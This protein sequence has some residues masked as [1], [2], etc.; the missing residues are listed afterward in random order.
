[1]KIS[2]LKTLLRL[3]IIPLLAFALLGCQDSGDDLEDA[4]EATMDATEE[5]ADT[6]MDASEDAMLGC[7]LPARINRAAEGSRIFKGLRYE[8]G[9][10]KSQIHYRPT[11][12]EMKASESQ[13]LNL[14]GELFTFIELSCDMMPHPLSLLYDPE[15]ERA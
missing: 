2:T 5:A 1:M 10:V 13:P 15:K 12:V 6:A 7:G 9:V 4:G 11:E 3:L 14:D 8:A